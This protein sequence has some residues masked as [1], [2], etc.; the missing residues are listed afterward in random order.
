MQGWIYFSSYDADKYLFLII[1]NN[2]T[3]STGSLNKYNVFF[4]Q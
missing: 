2:F 4:T 3:G 1:I